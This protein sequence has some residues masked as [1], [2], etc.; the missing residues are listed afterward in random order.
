MGATFA[1]RL[2]AARMGR[3]FA[4]ETGTGCG[5]DCSA[6]EAPATNVAPALSAEVR[7]YCHRTLETHMLH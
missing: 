3:E 5:F 4:E 7:A 6:R 2:A 1:K